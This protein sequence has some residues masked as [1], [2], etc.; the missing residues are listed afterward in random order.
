[1]PAETVPERW[2]HRALDVRMVPLLPD[3][4]AQVLAGDFADPVLHGGDVGLAR[5]IAAGLSNQAIAH[6]LGVDPRTVQ[7]RTTALRDR[8][9]AAS[10]SDL[11][12]LL[13]ARGFG[14]S[15]SPK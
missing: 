12:V 13:A 9:G 7:R 14:S 3:E 2:A 8:L 1:M 6:R 11:A 15:E 10:K 4:A 5:L